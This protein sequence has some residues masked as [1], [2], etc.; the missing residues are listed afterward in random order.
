MVDHF[1]E[2]SMIIVIPKIRSTWTAIAIR[3]KKNNNQKRTVFIITIIIII[4]IIIIVICHL[5]FICLFHRLKMLY[6]FD[7][8]Y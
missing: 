7:I 5:L 1:D 4:I 2:H 3:A 8:L 6:T